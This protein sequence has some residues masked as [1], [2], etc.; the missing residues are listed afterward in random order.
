MHSYKVRLKVSRGVL[1]RHKGTG[2]T[3]LQLVFPVQTFAKG[4]CAMLHGCADEILAKNKR[5]EWSF[6]KVKIFFPG[7]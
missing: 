6:Q 7:C 2:V 3:V 5:V 1:A 4:N